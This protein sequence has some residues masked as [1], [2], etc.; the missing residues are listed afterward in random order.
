M[1]REQGCKRGRDDD[2]KVGRNVGSVASRGIRFIRRRAEG[3]RRFRV[4]S[5]KGYCARRSVDVRGPRR[6]RVAPAGYPKHRGEARRR[7]LPWKKD[8]VLQVALGRPLRSATGCG[9]TRERNGV[10]DTHEWRN[11]C[12]MFRSPFWVKVEVEIWK[13]GGTGLSRDQR[14]RCLGRCTVL[15]CFLGQLTHERRAPSL[16]AVEVFSSP[17]SNR[18]LTDGRLHHR[19]NRLTTTP[20]Q[21]AWH[22][23]RNFHSQGVAR[24]LCAPSSSPDRGNARVPVVERAAGHECARQHIRT[25]YFGIPRTRNNSKCD[26]QSHAG[27]R[28]LAP[29]VRR[30]PPI[31]PTPTLPHQD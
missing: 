3:G 2:D 9:K 6:K 25:P 4:G 29:A 17:T 16:L 13:E 18:P 31:C 7:R 21:R 30:N 12:W 22:Q 10:T 15:V 19:A 24:W 5:T 1:C 20:V 26:I 8:G 28:K 14:Y 11:V 27:L 23:G